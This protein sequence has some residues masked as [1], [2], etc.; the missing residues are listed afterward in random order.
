MLLDYKG[1]VCGAISVSGSIISFK[2]DKIEE[3]S[4]LIME[5]ALKIS[6][7]LGYRL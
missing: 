6:K 2:E 4:K 3:F 7:E 1:E 5:Y